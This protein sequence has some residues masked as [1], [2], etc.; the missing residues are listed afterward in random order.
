MNIEFPEQQPKR[1]YTDRFDI[2][3]AARDAVKQREEHYGT[4]EDNAANIAAG[5]SVILGVYVEPR[6]VAM[7]LAWLKISRLIHDDT[8]LDNWIDLAGYAAYGGEVA[9]KDGSS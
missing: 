7:A 8:H 4:P 3:D 2:L 1:R 6:K 5:W 9:L